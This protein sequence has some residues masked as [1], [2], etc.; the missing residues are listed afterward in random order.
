MGFS[1][2]QSDIMNKQWK[3]ESG[4]SLIESMA[5]I[6]IIVTGMLTLGQVL[7][8]S[9]MAS[10][11]HGRDSG[12]ATVAARD[13][14][15]ELSE[16]S[17]GDSKLTAGGSLKAASRQNGYFDFL[18]EAGHVIQNEPSAAYT[19]YWLITDEEGWAFG[20]KRIAVS[21]AS[22]RSFKYGVAPST[23]MVTQKTP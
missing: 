11:T 21:V 22:N 2:I 15:E 1:I 20:R 3:N 9:I 23:I 5:A 14:M 13:K 6:L 10:K 17:I 8:L 4:I 18:D 19:R 12:K 16:L 7:T